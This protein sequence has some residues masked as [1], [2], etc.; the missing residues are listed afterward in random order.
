[1]LQRAVAVFEHAREYV[2]DTL[3]GAGNDID[4]LV[5]LLEGS[6][7]YVELP[8]ALAA[9]RSSAQ[10][11][12]SRDR[13][14]ALLAPIIFE[15][16]R[17]LPVGSG[18]TTLPELMQAIREHWRSP[19]Q[20]IAT[21]S[22][23]YA[24]PAAGPGNVGNVSLERLNVDED[25]N[26]YSDATIETKTFRCVADQNSGARKWAERWSLE[27]E[28]ASYDWAEMGRKGTGNQGLVL[29]TAHGGSGPNYL[30]NGTFAEF[31][32]AGTPKFSGWQEISGGG[33]I[34]E[35]TANTYRQ[36][37]GEST[38]RALRMTPSGSTVIELRQP[39]EFFRT[40]TFLRF[41][42]IYARVMVNRSLGAATGGSLT[43]TFGAQSITVN[44]GD[45]PTGWTEVRLPIGANLYR[46]AWNAD[47]LYFG[48]RWNPSSSTGY[49]LWDEATLV[50]WIQADATWWLPIMRAEAP[51]A[52]LAEDILTAANTGGA[53]GTG[54]IAYA[55]KIAGL[56]HLPTSGTP[57]LADPA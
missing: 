1:M 19:A 33:L 49:L 36:L 35:D 6:R 23:T 25:G 41:V 32:A 3:V 8:N 54:K 56:G 18:R 43:L 52:S 48:I 31:S 9:F 16:A 2:D 29:E 24:A 22:I 30:R 40:Q 55:L 51:V 12:I 27:G 47:P 57:T 37:P 11:L 26:P 4:Q 46:K 5:Q 13:A 38:A 10:G 14:R 20:S 44:I 53:P 39:L 45:L 21:R 17:L 15:Y 34:T 42:P 7:V 28:E 50:P